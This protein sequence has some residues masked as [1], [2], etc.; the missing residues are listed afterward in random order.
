MNIDTPRDRSVNSS[1]NSSGELSIHSSVFFILY[2]KSYTSP[3]VR[4][5]N[6]NN[7]ATRLANI[8]AWRGY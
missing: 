6:T 3:K 5:D 1:T 7:K 2:I 8:S 4:D